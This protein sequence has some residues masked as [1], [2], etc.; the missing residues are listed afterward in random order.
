[1]CDKC[2]NETC[3]CLDNQKGAVP[4]QA[5]PVASTAPTLKP[6]G[7]LNDSDG[8]LSSGRLVKVCSFAISALVAI[9]CTIFAVIQLM[10]GKP[11]TQD[12]INFTLGVT[13]IFMATATAGEV[14]QKITGK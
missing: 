12:F 9:G 8:N 11:I 2:K 3:T 5:V 6:N 7:F 13:G 14:V 10:N 4:T 1:M